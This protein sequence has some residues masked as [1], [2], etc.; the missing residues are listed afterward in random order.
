MFEI[1]QLEQFV[2]IVEEETISKAAEKLLISQPALSRSLKSFEDSLG[3]KLFERTKNNITLNENGELAYQK[4][5]KLLK[6]AYQMKEDLVKY[7]QNNTL[8]NLAA[9]APAPIW[10]MEYIFSDNKLNSVMAESSN[11][12]LDGLYKN[13]YSL[14]ILNH[15]VE[16]RDLICVPLFCEKLYLSVVPEHPFAE[17]EFTSFSEIDGETLLLSSRI[18]F[19]SQLCKLNLPH[20]R[21]LYQDDDVIQELVNSS[22][23]PAF[24]TDVTIKRFQ[25]H[26]NRIYIPIVDQEAKNQYFLYYKKENRQKYDFIKQE[27]GLIDWQKTNR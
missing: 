19:W 10:A 3:I 22:N 4:A 15:Y 20:S 27:I 6:A 9:C 13:H 26:E 12:M 8:T 18:G 24:R 21:L 2:M 11:E 17:K 5:K 25:N 7:D 14:I 16:K 1:R 23:L